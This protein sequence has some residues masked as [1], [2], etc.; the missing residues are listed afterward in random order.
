MFE[1]FK[2]INWKMQGLD[3]KKIKE[4]RLAKEQ[5]KRS[6][7]RVFIITTG[8]LFFIIMVFNVIMSVK[9]AAFGLAVKN[10][11]ITLLTAAAVVISIVNKKMSEIISLVCFIIALTL[12]QLIK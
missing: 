2:E 7:L 11:L 5:K 8:I 4:E 10:T 12:S 9:E 1:F 3:V 6:V